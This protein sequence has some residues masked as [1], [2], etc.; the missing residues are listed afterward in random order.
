MDGM[1]EIR[2]KVPRHELVLVNGLEKPVVTHGTVLRTY[3]DEGLE[4]DETDAEHILCTL[5]VPP[6]GYEAVEQEAE[7]RPIRELR[8][9]LNQLPPGMHYQ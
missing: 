3:K 7:L 1:R 2:W 8:T 5:E 4:A 6:N 9:S